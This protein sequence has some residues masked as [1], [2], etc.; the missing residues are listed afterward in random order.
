MKPVRY[1][2]SPSTDPYWNLALEEYVFQT[3]S[4]DYD[5]FMLWQNHNTIVVGK[6][7]N[8]VEQINTRFVEQEGISVVRRC[9]GGGAVYHD[10][11]NLNFTFIVDAEQ[12]ESLNF[13]RFCQPVVE[14]LGQCG[15]TAEISGR[16][17]MTIEGKKFSGNSQYLQQGR[18][19]HHGTMMFNSNL[20]VLQE[21]LQVTQD[22][23]QSKGVPSIRSRVTNIADHL[24]RPCT[25]EDYHNTLVE[26]VGQTCV[27]EPFPLTPE[28]ELAVEA[29]A[30]EKYRT[31][32]WNYGR[33]PKYAITKKR[34][35]EGCG[36]VELSYTVE[37]GCIHEL[38]FF[39]DFF[40][41]GDLEELCAHLKGCLCQEEAML[42]RLASIEID[43]YVHKLTPREFSRLILE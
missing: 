3:L 38:A 43:W 36:L 21:S 34:R 13:Q 17:D 26:T 7:Q 25:L 29:L 1:I 32:E 33:S 24:T 12:V 6:Y 15:V 42:A 37:K 4:R 30:K 8:T 16:N 9:S 41:S 5:Y 28:I 35:I 18:V 20:D 11:G 23:I 31:W 10:L 40:G 14:A 19:M 22:K 27:L 39:G 2:S